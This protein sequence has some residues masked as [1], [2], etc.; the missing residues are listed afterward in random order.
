[1]AVE[2]GCGSRRE[3]GLVAPGSNPAPV[4]AEG[5]LEVKGDAR[6]AVDHA[7]V[8]KATLNRFALRALFDENPEEFKRTTLGILVPDA[9]RALVLA[10]RGRPPFKGPQRW[11]VR[12]VMEAAK[13]T[14][15]QNQV[16]ILIQQQYIRA[17]QTDIEALLT[18]IKL[19]R[20]AAA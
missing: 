19:P 7:P 15:Q 4:K 11:A 6:E 20:D 8:G 18:K 9:V 12:I 17:S 5:R 2:Q 1:M 14:G 3:S 10:L 16:S 13:W